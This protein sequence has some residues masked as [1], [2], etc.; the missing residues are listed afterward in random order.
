MGTLVS[1]G[2]FR[3]GSPMVPARLLH[4]KVDLTSVSPRA[5]GAAAS[6]GGAPPTAAPSAPLDRVSSAAEGCTHALAAAL[7]AGAA[8]GPSPRALASRKLSLQSFL[9]VMFEA[10]RDAMR[11]ENQ[12]LMQH[13][14]TLREGLAARRAVSD[15][16]P[17]GT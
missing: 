6:L 17:Q 2:R 11:H 14:H 1:R 3:V 16:G 5:A 8:G 15:A 4:R 13:N 10:Q 7:Q 9:L 12:M